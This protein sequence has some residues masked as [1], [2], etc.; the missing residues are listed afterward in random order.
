MKKLLLLLL[1]LLFMV[2]CGYD[3]YVRVESD[4][5][6]EGHIGD[7]KIDLVS[8]QHP[9]TGE[10]CTNI[11]SGTYLVEPPGS[12]RLEKKGIEGYLRMRFI[13]TPKSPFVAQEKGPWVETTAPY[14]VVELFY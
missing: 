4:V 11:L 2:G 5:L 7:N 1:L 8:Y 14:G 10:W 12:A 6:Y 13:K 3:Y 9:N